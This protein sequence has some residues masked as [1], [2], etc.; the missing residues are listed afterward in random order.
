[1]NDSPARTESN[2]KGEANSTSTSRTATPKSVGENNN[3]TPI[4][5]DAKNIWECPGVRGALVAVGSAFGSFALL[6]P[7]VPA[8]VLAN[9]GTEAAAGATTAI[10]MA[11]TV[12]TQMFT[13]AMLRRM[14]YLPVVVISAVLLGLPALGYSFGDSLALYLSISAIRGIGFGALTVAASALVAELVPQ[15]LLGKASGWMGV[16]IGFA[17]LVGLPLGLA[18]ADMTSTNTV[19]YIAA[20]IAIVAGLMSLA[21]PNV[22]A[23]RRDADDA[24][25]RPQVAIWKLVLIPAGAMCTVAMGFGT[26]SSF[27]PTAVVDTDPKAGVIV[28]S[29]V[30]SMIGGAQMVFRYWAG[31]FTDRV[32]A[33]G[34]LMIPGLALTIA[35][36]ATMSAVVGLGL[37][38]WLAVLG[39]FVFGAGFGMVQN[40][41]LMLMFARLPRTKVSEASAIWNIS[42]DSGTGSGSIVMGVIAGHYAYQGAFA[43]AAL[44][45]LA[46]TVAVLADQLAGR[47]RIVEVGNTSAR[48]KQVIAQ[49]PRRF[50]RRSPVRTA[51][52]VIVDS[53]ADTSGPGNAAE[54]PDTAATANTNSGN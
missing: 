4:P 28:A 19:Y 49:R 1:M 14:G 15:R 25:T 45:I 12:I 43:A 36:L 53:A 37:N 42:F 40:E 17:E 32:G 39:A 22:K 23:H 46:A 10:F 29:V 21:V 35:G 2:S 44:I 54:T 27:L 34:K 33:P 8:A 52:K 18:I 47:Y 41:A 5:E 26:V 38:V 20:G 6:L 24:S 13:P 48:M 3:R 30:L 51:T 11:A 7:L 16:V 31:S 50:I 9:G